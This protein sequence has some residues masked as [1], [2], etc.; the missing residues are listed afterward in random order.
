MHT[1]PG[2][3]CTKEVPTHHLACRR[4]WYQVTHSTRKLVWDAWQNGSGSGTTDHHHAM[5]QAVK[6]MRP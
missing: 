3:K 6:E 4:H 2:P 5:Q 1:C